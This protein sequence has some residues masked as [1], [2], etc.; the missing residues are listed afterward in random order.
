MIETPEERRRRQQREYRR[1][2]KT[3]AH[4]V[5]VDLYAKDV[6]ALERLGFY[7]DG[8]DHSAAIRHLLEGARVIHEWAEA[9]ERLKAPVLNLP[10]SRK[11][12][13]A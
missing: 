12:E 9:V 13:I 5:G 1:R 7:R 10:N 11:R 3:G 4:R 8:E 6:E 2:R